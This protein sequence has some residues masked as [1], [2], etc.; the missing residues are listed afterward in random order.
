M[1]SQTWD[2]SVKQK[3]NILATASP[4]QGRGV[5]GGGPC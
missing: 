2:N 4:K 5:C 1:H 3:Q